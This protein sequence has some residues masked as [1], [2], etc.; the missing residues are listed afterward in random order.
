M[1]EGLGG[2]NEKAPRVAGPLAVMAVEVDLSFLPGRLDAQML[3][4]DPLNL[5]AGEVEGCGFH[6]T[7]RPEILAAPGA[8]QVFGIVGR[9][10]GVVDDS[11][12]TC[13]AA[14]G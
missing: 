1:V 10:V 11:G 9:I 12:T 2:E 6:L 3:P 4:G 13:F 14:E 5:L 8:E 7:K